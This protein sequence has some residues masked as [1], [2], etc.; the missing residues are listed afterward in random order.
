MSE[1]SDDIPVPPSAV[2]VARRALI[3]CGVV[4]RANLEHYSDDAYRRETAGLIKKWFDEL[5]LWPHLEPREKKIIRARFGAMPNG[6]RI[7][8][9]WLVEGL[10]LLAWA[11]RRGDFPPH[12]R[13]VDAFA[14]TDALGFLEPGAS[15]LLAAPDLRP[16]K[17]LQAAREWFYDVHVSLRQFL[18]Y[19]GDGRLAFW[20]GK[21]ARALGLDRKQV[22]FRKGL[23]FAGRPLAEA[24]RERLE[25][26]ECVIRER[27][28]AAIWLAGE[29]DAPYTEIAVDT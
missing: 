23:A 21:Y 29:D 6:L 5:A 12:D 20:I 17:E 27:H 25:D 1:E 18:Y 2:D 10:A 15:G 4:C 19:Q 9:T 28:R 13:K 26:W 7:E 8:G 11:L 3:L 24:D 14:V 16:A 22:M